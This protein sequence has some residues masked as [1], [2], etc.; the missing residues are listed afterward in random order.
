VRRIARVY[1]RSDEIRWRMLVTT[2]RFTSHIAIISVALVAVLLA[3]LKLGSGSDSRAQ[4]L[5]A[6]AVAAPV[7][8]SETNVGGGRAYSP[9]SVQSYLSLINMDGGLLARRA[10][11]DTAVPVETR[12]GIITYTVQSGDTVETI[13]AR[14]RLLPST[15]L[16][17][18]EEV[19][20]T[21]DRL[22]IGQEL[23]IL[24]VD[25]IYHMV[26]ADETITGIAEEFKAKPEDIIGESL[27]NLTASS[28]L[29]PG[30]RL[31]VPFGVK[32]FVPPVV[33]ASGISAGA[34]SGPAVRA[35]GSGAFLWPASGMLTSYYGW[36]HGGIDV[37]NGIGV[38]ILAADGGYVSFAGWDGSGYGWMVIL[39]HG[40]GFS[41]L[42]AHLS[43][44][45]V[46]P[47][48]PVARGQVIGAMGSSGRSTGPHVHF[49]IRYGGVQQ[50]PLFYLP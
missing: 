38:P 7:A 44:Y 14:F 18:N 39:D 13:A 31:V 46:D 47:G 26:Q 1:L 40:N 20:K 11:A 45:Y 10:V 32:P 6:A 28:N 34:Y 25:G 22:S 42:Y 9:A 24:P 36:G 23:N 3:G 19:E 16:W 21:P 49:E 41:S 48:Q 8:R 17:S 35:A 37:A 4:D 15:I 50:N 43:Q 30:T 2:S 27:N 33:T 29:L 12:S 5:P